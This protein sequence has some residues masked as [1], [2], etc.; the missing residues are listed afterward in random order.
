MSKKITKNKAAAVV[1]APAPKKAKTPS[2]KLISYTLKAVIPTGQYANIQ[3]EITV[4]AKSIEAAERAVMPYIETLFAKYRDGGV[5]P[6]E[7][8]PV[9]P[10]AP[11]PAPKTITVPAESIQPAPMPAQKPQPSITIPVGNTVPASN[12]VAAPAIVLTVPFNRAKG[13]IDSCMSLEA[14]KLVSDQV[15]KSTKLI[16]TEKAE[17]RKIA[18]AKLETLNGPKKV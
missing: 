18:A 13:A 7:A 12:A 3:P 17:L 16:D 2:F 8:A 14:L 11:A 1:A 9:R 15:E 5:K 10:V 4:Q 6:V